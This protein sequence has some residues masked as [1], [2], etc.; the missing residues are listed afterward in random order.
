VWATERCGTF[1]TL[2][3]LPWAALAQVAGANL[4]GPPPVPHA[5]R[6]EALPQPATR[7]ALDL[8]A[9]TRGFGAD[10]AAPTLAARGEAQLLVF[11]SLAMP[12]A[13][14]RRLV[15]QA[16]RARA[17]LVLRGLSEGSLVRTATRVQALIGRQ[18]TAIEIDPRDFDRFSI[19][20]VPTFVLVK[21]DAASATAGCSTGQC[22]G[23]THASIAGDVTLD[24]ALR[25]IADRAP[26]F[27]GDATRL[28]ER[29]RP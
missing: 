28:L 1:T 17:R 27:R 3:S 8:E 23:T 13:R 4:P 26:A 29:L 10:A 16:A 15:N 9:I 14:L 5:P 7:E 18:Q 21:A 20:Q 11:I 22:A 25:Q 2:L 12:E 24:Y 19:S 6:I